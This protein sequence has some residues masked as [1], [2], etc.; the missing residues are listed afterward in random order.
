MVNE[1]GGDPHLIHSIV[2]QNSLPD[3]EIQ[4]VFV[5]ARFYIAVEK[6]EHQRSPRPNSFFGSLA[7]PEQ[8]LLL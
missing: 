7:A 1:G 5:L 8:I 3:S 2:A 6:M 4:D